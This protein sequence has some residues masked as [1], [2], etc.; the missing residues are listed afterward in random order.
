MTISS[1]ALAAGFFGLLSIS[2]TSAA[3]LYVDTPMESSPAAN[4]ASHWDGPY[5]GIFTG[6]LSGTYEFN[7]EGLTEHDATGWL[8][9]VNIGYDKVLDNGLVVGVVADAA[10]SK[11]SVADQPSASVNWL[12]SLRGRAGYDA[13]AYLPYLTGGIAAAGVKYGN[14]SAAFVG[15]TVGAGIEVAATDQLSVDFQYRYSDYG[16]NTAVFGDGYRTHQLTAGLNWRF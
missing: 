1:R 4:A 7:G 15:W 6:Y 10:W 16:N 14:S 12:A 2:A 13:G 5:V 11:V 9:G 3:D 8:L